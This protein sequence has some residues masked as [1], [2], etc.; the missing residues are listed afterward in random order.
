[1]KIFGETNETKNR[2]KEQGLSTGYLDAKPDIESAIDYAY[3]LNDNKQI[4]LLG[5]SYSSALA[6]LISAK[7][8]KVKSVIAFSPDEH[9]KGVNLA[10]KIKNIN[11]PIFA[12]SAKKEIK[13]VSEVLKFVDKKHIT[14]FKPNIEGFHGSKT[15]WE[16]VNGFETYWEALK[17]FLIKTE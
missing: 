17:E 14:H 3:N 11:I 10:V 7:S 9:L 12:T 2:A 1:M 5:S 16:V 6:L 15:I 13:Q 8:E 4:I